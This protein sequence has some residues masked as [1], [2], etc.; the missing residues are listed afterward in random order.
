MTV[1]PNIYT[2]YT[3]FSGALSLVAS[4]PEIV[5]NKTPKKEKQLTDECILISLLKGKNRIGY[6]KLYDSYA[7]TLFGVINKII[8]D[9]TI[10]EDLLSETFVKIIAALDQYNP[11]RGRFFT[12]M[13]NIARNLCFD[14]LRSKEHRNSRRNKDID[15]SA[16]ELHNHTTSFNPDHIDL[17]KLSRQLHPNQ[18]ILIDLAYFKGYTHSEIAEEL[19][20]PLGTVKTRMR[21]AINELRQVFIYQKVS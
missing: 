1:S 10:A 5:Y 7:S 15:L 13:I 20:M 2:K 9:I 6:E 21:M 14:K 12:W 18:M 3:R 17:G 4:I 19:S 8:P 16:A 11:S